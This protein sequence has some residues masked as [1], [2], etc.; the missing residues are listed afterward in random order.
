VSLGPMC[1]DSFYSQIMYDDASYPEDEKE[2]GNHG[3]SPQEMTKKAEKVILKKKHKRVQVFVPDITEK[4]I[5]EKRHNRAQAFVDDPP[6]YSAYA[7]EDDVKA[8]Q[9]AFVLKQEASETILLRHSLSQDT[10]MSTE[11]TGSATESKKRLHRFRIARDRFRI[12]R[13]SSHLG[14]KSRARSSHFL[15]AEGGKV[16]AEAGTGIAE[17]ETAVEQPTTETSFKET[18]VEVSSD[19]TPLKSNEIPMA[20]FVMPPEISPM[21]S[22]VKSSVVEQDDDDATASLSD[23]EATPK[24]KSAWGLFRRRAS[25]AEVSGTD[26]DAETIG[27]RRSSL[28]SIRSLGSR[29]SQGSRRSLSSLRSRLSSGGRRKD[30]DSDD[31]STSMEE[32][33]PL[34]VSLSCNI[35]LLSSLQLIYTVPFYQSRKR[36]IFD[37]NEE[38]DPSWFNF[39]DSCY[40]FECLF[41]SMPDE[42]TPDKKK[43]R[44]FL[45][46]SKRQ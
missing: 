46:Q 32:Q 11:E 2:T 25:N 43:P 8:R 41:E 34:F 18:S 23:G 17:P 31:D 16:I 40:F 10:D 38:D 15:E 13:F 5:L 28:G 6:I 44:R 19:G 30:A 24:K 45:F 33:R 1:T 20:D 14:R 7:L 9:A 22:G 39:N 36:R 12:A 3:A 37:V 26:D 21:L 29:L 35:S 27:S 4:V 42:K